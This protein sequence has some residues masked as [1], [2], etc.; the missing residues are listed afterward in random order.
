MYIVVDDAERIWVSD[1]GRYEFPVM[2]TVFGLDGG[3]A[4]RVR[5]PE[6]FMLLDVADDRILGVWSDE[7]GVE[8][9]QIWRIDKTTEP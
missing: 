3:I 9:P 1:F 4:A 8:H 2:W 5:V 7:V 6:Q